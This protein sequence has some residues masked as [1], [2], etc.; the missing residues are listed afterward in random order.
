MHT[1]VFPL[2]QSSHDIAR[3]VDDNSTNISDSSVSGPAGC[4]YQQERGLPDICSIEPSIR[5]ARRLLLRHTGPRLQM[6][7]LPSQTSELGRDRVSSGIEV[8]DQIEVSG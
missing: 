1:T 3:L 8:Q 5:V 4:S 7:L 6:K 2:G